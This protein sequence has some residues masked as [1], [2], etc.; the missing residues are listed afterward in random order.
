MRRRIGLLVSLV[1]LLALGG[2]TLGATPAWATPPQHFHQQFN[3]SIPDD[4][5]SAA[6]GFDVVVGNPTLNG[7][8]ATFTMPG[9]AAVLLRV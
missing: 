8:H 9:N 4:E 2:G 5:L 6:C 1:A 3:L 7:G